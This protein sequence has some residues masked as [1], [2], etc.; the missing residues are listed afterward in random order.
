MSA[1]SLQPKRTTRRNVLTGT[2][3][4]TSINSSNR[5]QLKHAIVTTAQN[6]VMSSG[7]SVNKSRFQRFLGKQYH[8]A[9]I[10]IPFNPV[11]LSSVSH[12]HV[13][14]GVSLCFR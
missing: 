1:W 6:V 7:A 12:T 11:I 8:F 4:T 10:K 5:L 2:I 13:S 3:V 9:I 14:R